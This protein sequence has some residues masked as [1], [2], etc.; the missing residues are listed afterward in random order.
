MSEPKAAA[1]AP[2]TDELAT[3]ARYPAPLDPASVPEHLQDNPLVRFL[4]DATPA[5]EAMFD[6]L[7]RSDEADDAETVARLQAE[8]K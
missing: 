3:V 1:D 6:T 8:A 2:S 7:A 5:Q 4:L